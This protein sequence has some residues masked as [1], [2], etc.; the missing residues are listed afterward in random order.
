MERDRATRAWLLAGALNGLLAVAMGAFAAH[1][2]EARL[3]VKAL[4]WI[5][6][7]ARY[8]MSH[9][10]ALLAVAWLASRAGTPRW[11]LRLA[12]WGFLLGCL[13]FCGLLYL[14]A[15]T[16]ARWLA[17]GVPFGGLAFMIGWIGLVLA[18][19]LGRKA[20]NVPSD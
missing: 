2:L 7:A 19:L 9:G 1:G 6:T 16:G 3:D 4:E 11:P 20:Q 12:G 5:E 14:M 8:Q 15:L 17:A 18:A 13:L 10:L